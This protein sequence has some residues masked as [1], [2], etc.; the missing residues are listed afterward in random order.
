MRQRVKI[1]D[2]EKLTGKH[3]QTIWRWCKEGRFP[4]PH[5]LGDSPDRLWFKDEIE[6]WE[7]ANMRQAG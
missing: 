4:K 1:R 5:Y 6:A 7:E 3:R 2:I